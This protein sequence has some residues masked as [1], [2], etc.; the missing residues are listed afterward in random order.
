MNVDVTKNSV[1]IQL[2]NAK[3]VESL[4]VENV[5]VSTF[6][7]DAERDE[8]VS[9]V[10]EDSVMIKVVNLSISMDETVKVLPVTTVVDKEATNALDVFRRTVDSVDTVKRLVVRLVVE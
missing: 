6:L 10:K 1:V 5:D 3:F 8:R 7:L 2:T 4:V 9:V